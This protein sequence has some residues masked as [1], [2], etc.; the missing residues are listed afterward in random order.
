VAIQRFPLQRSLPGV[1]APGER[2]DFESIPVFL[3]F[4]KIFATV[5]GFYVQYAE[6][7]CDACVS[8]WNVQVHRPE[9]GVWAFH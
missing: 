7:I 6:S 9:A 5:K 2:A 1:L 4:Q 8:A 3:T